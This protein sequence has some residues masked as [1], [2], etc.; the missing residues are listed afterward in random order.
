MSS[1]G[2]DGRIYFDHRLCQVLD[3]MDKSISI[4]D[5]VK[6][7]IRTNLFRSSILSS[8]GSDGRIYFDHRLCQVLDL[9]DKSI[10]IIDFIKCWI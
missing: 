3:L 7:W 6:C 1:G 9:M 2:S 5:F 4:I 10:S 8:A